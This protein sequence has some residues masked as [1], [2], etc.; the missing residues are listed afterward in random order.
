MLHGNKGR[1][2]LGGQS[3]RPEEAMLRESSRELS[4]RKPWGATWPLRRSHW[5]EPEL[6]LQQHGDDSGTSK[7]GQA[8]KGC[9]DCNRAF[10]S[11]SKDIYEVLRPYV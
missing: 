4:K 1:S 11:A 9:Y 6:K 2:L 8:F 7:V 5:G 3:S 10:N